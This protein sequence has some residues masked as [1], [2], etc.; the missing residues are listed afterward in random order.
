MDMIAIARISTAIVPN[1]GTTKEPMISI[2]S[3]PSG[4]AIV[5]VLS[6]EVV[7][8]S[9]STSSPSIRTK[10]VSS[11]PSGPIASIKSLGNVMVN[12]PSLV[13]EIQ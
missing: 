9:K 1:S 2:S 8:S 6:V 7:F 5:K 12:S 10:K 4:K 3:A 11:L 13:V